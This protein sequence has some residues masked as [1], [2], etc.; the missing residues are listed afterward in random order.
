MVPPCWVWQTSVHFAVS[1]LTGHLR[2]LHADVLLGRFAL[3]LIPAYE[4]EIERTPGANLGVGGDGGEA[5]G[6][7]WLATVNRV[8]AQV[9]KVRL[10]R[11]SVCLTRLLTILRQTLILA[12]VTVPSRERL[13]GLHGP[14][15]LKCYS[16]R[17]VTVRRFIPARMRE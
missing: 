6:W 8:N 1:G 12:Y 14:E 15:R 11:I 17:E 9:M 2:P 13:T 10:F 5:C 16:V 3:I 4:D 7:Q